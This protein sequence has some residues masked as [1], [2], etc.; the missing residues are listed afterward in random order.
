MLRR[1]AHKSVSFCDGFRRRCFSHMG[2]GLIPFLAVM[3]LAVPQLALAQNGLAVTV[4]PRSLEFTDEDGRTAGVNSAD[5]IYTVVLD[6]PPTDTVT[7]TVTGWSGTDV[8][9]DPEELEFTIDTWNDEKDVTVTVAEDADAVSERVILD[10]TATVGDDEVALSEVTVEVAIKDEDDKGVTVSETSRTVPEAGDPVMYT[11]VLDTE[12]T[13]TVTVDVG[14]ASGEITVSPSRLIFTAPST[15][16]GEDGN[17]DDAQ[18]VMVFA[19]ED[20]DAVDDTATLT[21]IVRGGDYTGELADSVVVTVDDDDEVGVMVSP[22]TLDVAVG[23]RGAYTIVLTS[24]P[25][26][27]VIISVAE[28]AAGVSVSP[29]SLRFTTSDWNQPETVTVTVTAVESGDVTLTH[30]A[31]SSDTEYDDENFTVDSVTVATSENQPL[32]RLSRSTLS[33]VEGASRTYTVRLAEEPS[34]GVTV[35][36]A[37]TTETVTVEPPS[38]DFTA[39]STPGGEGW[40]LGRC[41][42]GDGICGRGC[43]R[44]GRYRY[45]DVHGGH[46]DR[47]R[48]ESGSDGW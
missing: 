37:G 24:Q 4:N 46:R 44:G 22:T 29:S 34:T 43:R 48:A 3:L 18:T 7:V 31:S 21:H 26:S 13:H 42:N 15:P 28:E 41:S 19:A 32:V 12:P 20:A 40:Q 23:A 33:I 10:H 8:S 2:G 1:D 30:Q 38:L 45:V 16:G 27:T 35:T 5:P 25:R 9:V 14:G 39:P 17:W 6:A 36:V 11:V 47:K